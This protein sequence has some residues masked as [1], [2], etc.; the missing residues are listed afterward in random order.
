MKVNSFKYFLIVFIILATIYIEVFT[1]HVHPQDFSSNSN[2]VIQIRGNKFYKNGQEFVLKGFNYFPRNSLRQSMEKWRWNEVRDELDLAKAHGANVIRTFI[3]YGFSVGERYEPFEKDSVK[4]KKALTNGY[5]AA[6][7]SF[8]SIAKER[9]L[10]VIFSLFDFMPGWAF[11]VDT[12]RTEYMEHAYSYLKNLLVDN[13][14][15][16]NNTILAWDVLNE[17]DILYKKPISSG[18]KTTFDD[19]IVF[20]KDIIERMNSCIDSSTS[21]NEQ[22]ITVNFA[23]IDRSASLNDVVDF[24]SFQYYEDQAKFKEKIKKLDSLTD[25]P[26]VAM[27][28]GYHSNRIVFEKDSITIKDKKSVQVDSLG[29]QITALNCYLDLSLNYNSN[30]AGVLIWSL[31]DYK[32][33]PDFQSPE[34][35]WHRPVI[36]V[37]DTTLYAPDSVFV[38]YDNFNGV[39]D[40]ALTPKPSACQASKFFKNEFSNQI[41]LDFKYTKYDTNSYTSKTKDTTDLRTFGLYF[42]GPMKFISDEGIV[43]DSILFGSPDPIFGANKYQ[44]RGWYSNEEAYNTSCQ[45]SGNREKIAS[46]YYAPPQKT[47]YIFIRLASR[48]P[49]NELN[50]FFNNEPYSSETLVIDT[51]DKEFKVPTSVFM[52][53]DGLTNSF[54]LSQNYPNPFNPITTIKYQLK[55]SG[56]V[57]LCIFN[58]QGES[59]RILLDEEKR[60]AVYSI[61][62]DGRD[63][64]GIS[65]SSGVYFC[66]LIVGDFT[67]HK[68]MLL[69]R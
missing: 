57:Q 64:K 56:R 3:D 21:G 26:I 10:K 11:L 63:D 50:I 54:V 46:M 4:L 38:V 1:S 23:D 41:R 49:D 68:K 36:F 24:L 18:D 43:L 12:C 16:D 2:D 35:S 32:F 13:G 58:V 48:I 17:G 15:R 33:P 22:Y 61:C 69:I 47:D 53:N 5:A 52:K 7:D 66:Q 37:L 55:K 19:F 59:V 62:W 6:I 31:V 25:R 29:K 28:L 67:S 9:Q 40:T 30:L 27:E 20:C 34:K 45:W 51:T 42:I 44:G 65:V 14:L 60:P 39:F 8:L